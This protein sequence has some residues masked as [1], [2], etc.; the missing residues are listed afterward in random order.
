MPFNPGLPKNNAPVSSGELRDR[1][2]VLN[3]AITKLPTSPALLNSIASHAAGPVVSV[4][5]LRMNVTAPPTQSEVEA[6][7]DK[8]NELIAAL[9][10]G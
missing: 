1:F 5:P 2:N 6:I 4:L 3:E 8:L 7:R 10:R 9:R